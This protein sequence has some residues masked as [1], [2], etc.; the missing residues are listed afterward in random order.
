VPHSDVGVSGLGGF[1]MTDIVEP[2]EPSTITKKEVIDLLSR[3]NSGCE[4]RLKDFWKLL[5]TFQRAIE[6]NKID[7][8]TVYKLQN[9]IENLP[10]MRE[11]SKGDRMSTFAY[12]L[13]EQAVCDVVARLGHVLSVDVTP[14]LEFT[15]DVR[16]Y[17]AGTLPI[18][19]TPWQLRRA[20]L[21][22][23]DKL[24]AAQ[25]PRWG[26]GVPGSQKARR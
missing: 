2:R 10:V 4:H 23:I 9:F 19:G 24:K 21:V 16:A 14:L 3:F 6:A 1:E 5:G 15:H 11:L 18:D 8:A 25:F 12:I 20:A 22:A 13:I 7:E 26:L 17:A